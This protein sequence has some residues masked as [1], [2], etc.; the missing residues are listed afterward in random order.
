MLGTLV[1]YDLAGITEG[2]KIVLWGEHLSLRNPH[3][4][5]TEKALCQL[6]PC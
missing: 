6:E 2:G 3:G 1:D 5:S 4:E